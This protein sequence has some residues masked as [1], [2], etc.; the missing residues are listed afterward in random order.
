MAFVDHYSVLGLSPTATQDTIKRRY[1]ELV[2]TIHPDVNQGSAEQ[3]RLVTE[4][5]QVLSDPDRRKHFDVI[6]GLHKN[7]P[8]PTTSK[9]RPEPKSA[10]KTAPPK[11]KPATKGMSGDLKDRIAAAQ[12]M[13]AAG[14]LRD[15][16]TAAE[17]LIKSHPRL[18]LAYALLGDVY[19]SQQDLRRA[20][21]MYSL[22]IQ[23]EAKDSSFQRRYEQILD[24]LE[25]LSAEQAMSVED[26]QRAFGRVLLAQAIVQLALMT[27]VLIANQRP[28]DLLPVISSWTPAL[29][30]C[31]LLSGFATGAILSIAGQL[32]RWDSLGSHGG[33]F[34]RAGLL[35]VIALINFWVSALWYVITAMLQD[36]F[37]PALNTL[38]A[39]TIVLTVAF[40]MA[41]A[42][43]QFHD[44]MQALLWGGNLIFL[45]AL[46][47]WRIVD[48]IK[49]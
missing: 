36:A 2:R 48:G 6:R 33:N 3:F 13:F 49:G 30:I 35:G 7:G 26:R 5:Y 29:F 41:F 15:A 20:A 28:I 14:R 4:S 43:G 32:E 22:A 10:T 21:K 37:T 12:R 42:V 16:Q 31:L 47:G 17:D 25:K 1:R 38:F 44:A 39:W 9:P 11:E 8:P 18:G 45:G 24:E 27:A 19:R 23:F 34:S 40:T 46:A